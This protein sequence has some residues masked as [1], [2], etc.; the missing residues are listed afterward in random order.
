M[1]PILYL[2][3]GNGS[4]RSWWEDS[5]PYFS[6]LEPVPLELP[7]FGDNP[8]NEV[9]SLDRLARALIEMTQPGSRIF[10]A[11]VNGLVV[12]RALVLKPGHF[13]D[14]ILLAPV[15]AFLWERRFVKLMSPKPIRKF[16]HFL[17][18]NYPKL[19]KRKFSSQQWTDAQY[20]R[21]GEGYQKCRAF[22]TYFDIVKAENALDFPRPSRNLYRT[23]MGNT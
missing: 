1:K 11:G 6:Q 2:L 9:H 18:R 8:S 20:Q 16:I 15:G 17:L 4:I 14:V 23:D 10:A 3:S 22:Q 19:F 7:G 12:L 21:M 13:K 5:I